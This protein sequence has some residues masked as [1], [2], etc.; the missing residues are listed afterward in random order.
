M[1]T[2]LKELDETLDAAENAGWRASQWKGT[3]SYRGYTV[4]EMRDGEWRLCLE[5]TDG[6]CQRT[7]SS[8]LAPWVVE[9]IRRDKARQFTDH[10][11]WCTVTTEDGTKHRAKWTTNRLGD[12]GWFDSDGVRLEVEVVSWV[13]EPTGIQEQA[14]RMEEGRLSAVPCEEQLRRQRARD[15][16]LDWQRLIHHVETGDYP[17][18]VRKAVQ[19]VAREQMDHWAELREAK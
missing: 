6:N 2:T 9:E 11:C 19:E 7:W 3:E 16:R 17:L 5:R 1:I 15:Q 8:A 14:K 18:E 4:V 13:E 12:W 10:P